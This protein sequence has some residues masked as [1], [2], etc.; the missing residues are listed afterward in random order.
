MEIDRAVMKGVFMENMELAIV[1]DDA[2]YGRALSLGLLK[3]C[4]SFIMNVF[5]KDAFLDRMREGCENGE[6]PFSGKFDIV[7]WDGSE[8]GNI[9]GGNIVMLAEKPSSV[10][11]DSENGRYCLYRYSCAGSLVAGIFGIY[12][13]IQGKRPVFMGNRD[14][15]ILAFASWSGGTGC[16][17]V[18]VNTARE[19]CRFH[20]R[21]VFYISMEET[22]ST[23]GFIEAGSAAGGVNRY[24]YELFRQDDRAPF[25]EEYAVRDDFGVE[26]FA[27]SGGRNPLRRL[28]EKQMC[29]FLDSISAGGR[30]DTIVIDL[31]CGISDTDLL[32][33]EIADR[34]CF[35]T[36]PEDNRHREGRH[37]QHLICHL[38]ESVME[39]AV[40]AVN[41]VGAGEASQEGNSG[42]VPSDFTGT[43]IYIEKGKYFVTKD[44]V[45]RVSDEGGF[46]GGISRTAEAMMTPAGI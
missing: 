28:D 23:D 14:V 5:S 25:M 35:V 45:R 34:I 40:R 20:G 1:T 10:I 46:I 6:A 33:M 4:R 36:L 37:M 38:G 42:Y 41:M 19:L 30:Y 12:R 13:R 26:A 22:E 21:Q 32:C 39:K 9:C 16:S 15:R 3:L 7:L 8:A 31:G 11:T 17:T 43:V 18:A 44:G 27:P 29:V 2:E 24:L